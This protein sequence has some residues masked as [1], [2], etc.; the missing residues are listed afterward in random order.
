[1]YINLILFCHYG[2]GH[3]FFLYN[4]VEISAWRGITMIVFKRIWKPDPL[5]ITANSRNEVPDGVGQESRMAQ[6]QRHVL[7]QTTALYSVNL[8]TQL[9]QMDVVRLPF[10]IWKCAV[11]RMSKYQCCPMDLLV[12]LMVSVKWFIEPWFMSF[13]IYTIWE[14]ITIACCALPVFPFIC[15]A[16]TSKEVKTSMITCKR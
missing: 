16:M 4:F 8:N 7:L 10:V 11:I 3:E 12:N 5:L 13:C 2:S 6:L 9:S 1:M 14:E 15:L